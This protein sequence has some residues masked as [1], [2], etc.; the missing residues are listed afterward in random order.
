MRLS[1]GITPGGFRIEGGVVP[2]LRGRVIKTRFVRKLFLDRCLVCYA[3]DAICAR[4]EYHC[5]GCGD[6]KCRPY[7][8]IQLAY[9]SAIYIIDLGISSAVNFVRMEEL[10]L[11]SGQLIIDVPLKLTVENQGDWGEVRFECV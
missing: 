6:T 4:E 3:A 2:E 7:L 10:A 9:S 11:S 5:D 1:V 8:R